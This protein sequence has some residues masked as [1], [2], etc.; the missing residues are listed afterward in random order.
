M[1][2][3]PPMNAYQYVQQPSAY[4]APTFPMQPAPDHAQMLARDQGIED[5]PGALRGI[6]VV[7][8]SEAPSSPT[9]LAS[10]SQTEEVEVELSDE[11]QVRSNASLG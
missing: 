4:Y 5:Y 3:L 2:D 10:F 9:S 7:Q 11:V 1:E 6:E 8:P